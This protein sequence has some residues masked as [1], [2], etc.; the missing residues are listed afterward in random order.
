MP[1]YQKVS[2]LAVATALDGTEEFEVIQGG[3]SKRA[4]AAG[5]AVPAGFI[6]PYGS[7]TAPSGFLACDGAAVSRTTYAA[8]FAA[9]GETWGAGDS[10]T[11]FNVPDLEGAALRGTG[12]GTIDTRDKTGPA[13]GA[14]QEDQMQGH[15]HDTKYVASGGAGLR[16]NSDSLGTTVSGST[17]INAAQDPTTDSVN[18]APRT[19]SETQ[20]YAAGVLWCIKT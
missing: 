12:T 13:V 7:T 6:L 18:G 20:P 9:I 1:E 16:Y 2:D 17:S 8:L 3:T 15:W 5:F 14:F 19:G 10:S 11:T 4:T